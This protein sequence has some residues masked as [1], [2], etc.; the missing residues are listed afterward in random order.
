MINTAYS[1]YPIIDEVATK[2]MGWKV[3]KVQ[4]WDQENFDVWWSDLG[5]D[6]MFL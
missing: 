6:A 4:T 2:E 5:V 3:S 1:E